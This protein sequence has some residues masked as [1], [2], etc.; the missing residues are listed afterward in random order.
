MAESFFQTWIDTRGKIQKEQKR[1]E[2][3]LPLWDTA[4]PVWMKAW[5]SRR[6]AERVGWIM[7]WQVASRWT[8]FWQRRSGILAKMLYA[9]FVRHRNR[10]G[11]KLGIEMSTQN[12]GW[13]LLVVHAQ[14]IVVNG[15]AIVGKNFRMTGFNCI[16]K[17]KMGHDE[18]PRI[19]DNV[20][21]GLGAKILGDVEIGDNAIIGAGAVVVRSCPAPGTTLVGV[22]ARALS[23]ET[24]LTM[25]RDSSFA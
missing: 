10:L 21:L 19:G 25:N 12:V 14:G 6:K 4:C 16:G 9:G 11:L 2:P 15:Q 20:T 22:P 1:Y 7:K 5:I 23:R 13:G 17:G 8:D 24:D 18:C 3:Y